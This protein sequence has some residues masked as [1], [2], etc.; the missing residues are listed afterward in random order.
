MS[1]SSQLLSSLPNLHVQLPTAYSPLD[2]YL[3]A[4]VKHFIFSKRNGVRSLLLKS[5]I[6]NAISLLWVTQ[7]HSG[8]TTQTSPSVLSSPLHHLKVYRI[9]SILFFQFLSTLSS[10]FHT[11]LHMSNL[12][13][14]THKLL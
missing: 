4:S 11:T 6:T 10:F 9:Y 2:I 5:L 14:S 8:L 1:W 13:H 3:T 7:T 12:S